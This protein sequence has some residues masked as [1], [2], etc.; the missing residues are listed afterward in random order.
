MMHKVTAIAST[1]MLQPVFGLVSPAAA[2]QV[3]SQVAAAT[4]GSLIIV[5]G[6]RADL[7]GVATS[8]SEGQVSR[9]DLADRPI[10]RVAELL[11]AIPGFIAT[12]HSGGGKANQY[13][14]R[15]FNLDHGTDFAAF[16][17]GVPLNMRTHGHGQGFLDLNFIIPELVGQLDFTKG[18]YRADTGDFATAGA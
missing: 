14:L 8:A 11:E 17:D 6:R 7:I 15:G 4:P 10:Q 12:Q 9:E 5:T 3:D 13:F 18:P 16:H 1:L 2:Q